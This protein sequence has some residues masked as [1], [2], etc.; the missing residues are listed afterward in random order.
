MLAGRQRTGDRR[1]GAWNTRWVRKQQARSKGEELWGSAGRV[2]RILCMMGEVLD[3]GSSC[4]RGGSCKRYKL[5][6]LPLPPAFY[7]SRLF[8]S[9]RF[10]PLL[11]S[12]LPLS[13]LPFPVLLWHQNITP[14]EHPLSPTD[15]GSVPWGVASSYIFSRCIT[16]PQQRT[17]KIIDPYG[18]PAKALRNG[19]KPSSRWV[20]SNYGAVFESDWCLG[21]LSKLEVDLQEISCYTSVLIFSCA[22]GS[23]HQPIKQRNTPFFSFFFLNI[24]TER[25]I[26][27]RMISF[28][29]VDWRIGTRCILLYRNT[30]L[31]KFCFDNFFFF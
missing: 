25:C 31:S 10:A 21:V 5:S 29:T 2:S 1:V 18:S 11:L 20:N 4:H 6:L 30:F 27:E 12:A 28:A 14:L 19:P 8:S 7:C 24:L 9:L 22:S 3:S 26:A 17:G 16:R 23:L 15:S 13:S